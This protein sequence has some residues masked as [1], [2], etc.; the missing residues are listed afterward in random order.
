MTCK[1]FTYVKKL[2][3]CFYFLFLNQITKTLFLEIS[4][5]FHRCK[6]FTERNFFKYLKLT[7]HTPRLPFL[8]TSEPPAQIFESETL[9]FS[10]SS[11]GSLTW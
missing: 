9:H 4:N 6:L 7:S 1:N 11:I 10:L 8:P 2:L 3:T 5:K